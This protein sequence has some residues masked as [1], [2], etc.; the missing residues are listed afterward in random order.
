MPSLNI[1]VGA[2]VDRNLQVA[3]QPLVDGAKRA[4]TAIEAETNKAARAV[5]TNTKKGTK[6]AEARFRELEAEIT[7]GMKRGTNAGTAAIVKFAG[8]AKKNL[9]QTKRSFAELAAEAEKSLKKIDAAQKKAG[10]GS[11]LRRAASG[12]YEYAGGNDGTRAGFSRVGRAAM[13]IGKAAASKAFHLAGTLA[14][15]SGVNTGLGEIVHKNTE[16][17]RD[18]AYLSNASVMVEDPRNRKRV[19][20]QTLMAESLNVGEKTGTDANVALEGL[21]EFVG[22]TGDLQ[23]GRNILEQMAIY[24]KATGTNLGDMMSASADLSNQLEPGI[25]KGKALNDLMRGFVAQGHLGAVEIRQ[26]ASQMA[27]IGAASRTFEGGQHTISQMGAFAQAARGRGGAASASIAASSVMAF[28]DTFS[29]GARLGAFQ[30]MGV[31]IEG[32]NGRIRDPKKVLIDALVAAQTH[33]GGKIDSNWNK[34]FGTMFASTSARKAT[35]SFEDE[36]KK[37]G[38]GDAGVKAVEAEFDRLQRAMISNEEVMSSFERAMKTNASQAEVFNNAMRKVALQM[39]ADLTPAMISLG[40]AIIPIAKKLG[41]VV[42]TATGD[43]QGEILK[44]AAETDVK[45]ALATTAKQVAG[46]QISDATIEENANAAK[47]ALF[48][49]QRAEAELKGEQ[50]ALEQKKKEGYLSANPLGGFGLG[51]Y[52]WDKAAGTDEKGREATVEEKKKNL[53]QA[54]A[55]YDKMVATNEDIKRKLD[56]KLLVQIANVEELK[57]AMGPKV[58]ADG[59]T[60]SPEEKA[61]GHE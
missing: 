31:N 42:T 39:V 12:A 4:K 55:T 22:K 49:K 19:S 17:E 11:L 47:Q 21:R 48:S 18:A 30:K 32:A 35:K 43:K 37:A 7:G 25:D 10:S 52:L 26:L 13:G 23:T 9:A 45:E 36:F 27:K 5:S 59:R 33:N 3:F 46:G 1:R 24:S 15:A 6:D 50:A 58:G 20:A 34:N 38:G 53:E 60:P 61:G 2:S 28:T 56:G 44:D 29:K 14:H 40:K 16:L 41:G 8:D 54:T 57:G 51:S